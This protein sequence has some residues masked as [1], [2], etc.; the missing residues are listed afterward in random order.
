M[1]WGGGSGAAAA[2]REG[3]GTG[4]RVR[5]GGGSTNG[6]TMPHHDRGHSVCLPVKSS[7]NMGILSDNTIS[8]LSFKSMKS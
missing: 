4:L 5:D 7:G 2:E 6:S 8:P 3:G 1:R